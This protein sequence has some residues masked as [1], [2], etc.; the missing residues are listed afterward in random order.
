MHVL[1][2]IF[3][4]LDCDGLGLAPQASMEHSISQLACCL[5]CSQRRSFMSRCVVHGALQCSL[6]RYGRTELPPCRLCFTPNGLRK[7]GEHFWTLISSLRASH[8]LS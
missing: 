5:I 7:S 2:K 1:P 3:R 4:H 8:T 6:M